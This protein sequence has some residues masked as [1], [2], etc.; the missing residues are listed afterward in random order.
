MYCDGRLLS[1][2]EHSALFSLLG[3]TYGG[4]GI[5]TFALPNLCGRS[6]VGT[7]TGPG[8]PYVELG[9]MAGVDTV[10]L[11]VANLPS[12][13]HTATT[14]IAVSDG[15]ATQSTPSG[16][17]FAAAPDEV[18]A[19]AASAGSSLGAVA[20]TTVGAAGANLPVGIRNPYLGLRA[21]ICYEG[22]YPSRP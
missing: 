9:E 19:P 1:I 2:A 8:L 11:M 4:D 12:H 21:I 17:T 20:T 3:T 7:G 13:T 5:T 15:D 22:I 10:T 16:N 18:Y 14:T 6:A